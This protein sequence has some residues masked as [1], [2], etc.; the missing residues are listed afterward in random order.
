M[1]SKGIER[2]QWHEMGDVLILLKVNAKSYQNDH[3]T[4]TLTLNVLEKYLKWN[5]CLHQHKMQHNSFFVN[6]KYNSSGKINVYHIHVIHFIIHH[7][8]EKTKIKLRALVLSTYNLCLIRKDVF[9]SEG[10]LWYTISVR[11]F[12]FLFPWQIKAISLTFKISF[13]STPFHWSLSIPSENIRKP[14][15]FWC[16][17]RV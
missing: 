6:F 5:R 16:F 12:V 10:G 17:Q 14:E 13:Y 7:K 15:V 4:A 3:V 11:M 2:H 8:H 1:I 9:A